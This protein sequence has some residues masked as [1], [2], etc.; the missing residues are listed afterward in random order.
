MNT[1]LSSLLS[2]I[3]IIPPCLVFG[4][5]CYYLTKKNAVEGILMVI[6]S[7]IGLLITLFYSAVMPLLINGRNLAYTE[8][9]QY[10]NLIGII[11]FIASIC[12]AAGLFILVYNTVKKN[13][14]PYNEFPKSNDYKHNE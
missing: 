7:G 13:N 12:F 4:T 3:A 11:S 1:I 14:A 8:I 5:C 9:S 10:Y 2:L 6:G